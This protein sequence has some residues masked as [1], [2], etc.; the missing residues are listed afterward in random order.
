DD[1]N[2]LKHVSPK[3]RRKFRKKE[4]LAEQELFEARKQLFNSEKARPSIS[5]KNEPGLLMRH[6]FN[7]ELPHP[8]LKRL[9]P[10]KSQIEILGNKR[11]ELDNEINLLEQEIKTGKGL[12]QKAKEKLRV[13]NAIKKRKELFENTTDG[14]PGTQYSK[15]I[16]TGTPFTDN[17]YH[18]NA[19]ANS[20][21]ITEE[22]VIS[23]MAR[24][25]EGL[26]KMSDVADFK[27]KFN[28]FGVG[29]STDFT[30]LLD[31][32]IADG[33]QV[34][35]GKAAYDFTTTYTQHVP[36]DATK[37]NTAYPNSRG[38]DAIITDFYNWLRLVND[39]KKTVNGAEKTFIET[40]DK[41]ITHTETIPVYLP[42]ET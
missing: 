25:C 33:K 29:S 42:S 37:H 6:K 1:P 26:S 38:V 24:I 17:Q 18:F 8:S 35:K 39:A 2:W 14:A 4:E 34:K 40:L 22:Q 10:H 27:A 16:T 30:T 32:L 23:I 12:G 13:Y 11:V 5:S 3:E 9:I 36:N 7:P 21:K 41:D 20:Y 19:D 31:R 15:P 28:S